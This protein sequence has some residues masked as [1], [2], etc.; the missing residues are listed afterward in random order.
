MVEDTFTQKELH[1]APLVEPFAYIASDDG[2]HNF[3]NFEERQLVSG[4][5]YKLATKE[6]YSLIDFLK[7]GYKI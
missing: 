7:V 4:A 5:L 6:Y 3:L 2:D 1:R